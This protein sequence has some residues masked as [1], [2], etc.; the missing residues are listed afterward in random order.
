MYHGSRWHDSFPALM[1]LLNNKTPLLNNEF[2]LCHSSFGLVTG[3]FQSVMS[4]FVILSYNDL[5]K[6]LLPF[7]RKKMVYYIRFYMCC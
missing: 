4:R 7:Y 6:Y 2:V 3:M 1:V 5:L